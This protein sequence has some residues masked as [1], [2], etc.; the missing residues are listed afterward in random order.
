MFFVFIVIQKKGELSAVKNIYKKKN[1]VLSATECQ[2]QT[3]SNTQ[4]K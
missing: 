3:L 4:V 1:A 2:G